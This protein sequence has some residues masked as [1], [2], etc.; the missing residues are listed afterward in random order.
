MLFRLVG[1]L[2]QFNH[3]KRREF[4]TLVFTAAPTWPPP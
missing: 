4:I 2:M 3:F 1:D